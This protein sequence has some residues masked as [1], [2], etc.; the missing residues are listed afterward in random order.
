VANVGGALTPIGDPPLFLGFLRGVPFFWTLEHVW[1]IWLPATALILAVFY[2]F[3]KRNKDVGPDVDPDQPKITLHGSKSFIWVAVIIASV[4]IDPNLFSWIPNLHKEFGVPLGIREIIMFTVAVLAYRTANKEAL[5]KNEFN[6]EPIREVAW[7][8]LGIFATM[9]P[10]LQLI[11]NFAQQNADSLSVGMFY[12]G[13]GALSGILDNAPTYLNFLAA[14]MGK[15]ALDVNLPTDV[16]TF[17]GGVLQHGASSA[18]TLEAISVAAV[19]FGALSYIGNAPN[20]MVKAI[21]EANGVET[22]SFMGYILR[23]SLPILLPI[24]FIIYLIFF[25]GWIL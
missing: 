18:I 21:A 3:D 4:F 19:F 15:F 7:L 16:F 12:W 1:F 6:F 20:F 22:P 9:Q 5:E 23:Y 25:S 11:S 8:F 17:A 10:A 13:T 2:M 24:Y 14:A